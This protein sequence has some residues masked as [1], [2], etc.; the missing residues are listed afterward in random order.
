MARVQSWN[1]S[2]HCLESAVTHASPA[3]VPDAHLQTERLLA[4]GR[5]LGRPQVPERQERVVGLGVG[6]GLVPG[7]S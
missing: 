6:W 3:G 2:R 5:K 4:A 1:S 7:H